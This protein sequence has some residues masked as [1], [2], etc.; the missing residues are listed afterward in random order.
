MTPVQRARQQHEGK[1]KRN[2]GSPH[3][4]RIRRWCSSALS[5]TFLLALSVLF[6]SGCF[7]NKGAEKDTK[8]TPPLEENKSIGP[9][10]AID[11]RVV[12]T[13]ISGNPQA[14]AEALLEVTL[15]ERSALACVELLLP[16]L[17]ECGEKMD[18]AVLTREE[19]QP[20]WMRLYKSYYDYSQ[21]MPS[22]K[23]QIL[24]RLA[25]CIREASPSLERANARKSLLNVL[26]PELQEITSAS[27]RIAKR[28][29][30]FSVPFDVYVKADSGWEDLFALLDTFIFSEELKIK[31]DD[32]IIGAKARNELSEVSAAYLHYC[33][34]YPE[35]E[36]EILLKY[37]SQFGEDFKEGLDGAKK[38]PWAPQFCDE[39]T[40]RALLTKNTTELVALFA[41]PKRHQGNFAIEG[42]LTGTRQA[43]AESFPLV[44]PYL[45]TYRE[46]RKSFYQWAPL[47]QKY[48]VPVAESAENEEIERQ[49]WIMEE[50]I[51][52][53][54]RGER[55]DPKSGADP[56]CLLRFLVVTVAEADKDPEERTVQQPYG[57]ERIV[58]VLLDQTLSTTIG[59]AESTRRELD[60][61][62]KFDES[63][64]RSIEQGLVA[65]KK[66]ISNQ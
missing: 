3:V 28:T 29:T 62:C 27:C 63:T 40:Y 12:A 50:L 61:L 7:M 6:T 15:D 42:L 9:L 47:L 4:L 26:A 46:S 22:R 51:G 5:L 43:R 2:G 14:A 41:G 45:E 36:E 32:P 64:A 39:S 30:L 60:V 18:D 19:G 17:A 20:V 44:K 25:D 49:Q 52:Q 48:C 57:K 23:H 58:E 8:S 10:P 31:L 24:L 1:A 21:G 53:I 56:I 13:I 54:E 66:S 38:S 65:R 16:R 37:L 35:R 34:Q 59:A 11:P 33:L 55:G